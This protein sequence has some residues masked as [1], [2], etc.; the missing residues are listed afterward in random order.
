MVELTSVV[1]S[2]IKSDVRY[3][4]FGRISRG[5]NGSTIVLG[6]ADAVFDHIS[7]VGDRCSKNCIL[8]LPKVLEVHFATSSFRKSD[9]DGEM[10]WT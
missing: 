2:R 3:F 5:K 6:F 10:W 1:R 7:W 9:K 4:W 8:Q